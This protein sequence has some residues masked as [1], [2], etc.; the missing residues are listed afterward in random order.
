[1]F[2]HLTKTY[3]WFMALTEKDLLHKSMYPTVAEVEL[4]WGI[5]RRPLNL[6]SGYQESR[7]HLVY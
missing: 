1:M 3:Q 6:P 5:E 2:Q 4:P 7:D